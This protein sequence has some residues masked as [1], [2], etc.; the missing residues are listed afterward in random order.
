MLQSTML[1][2]LTFNL[3]RL[4]ASE[5]QALPFFSR[6]AGSPSHLHRCGTRKSMAGTGSWMREWFS[7]HSSDLALKTA[8]LSRAGSSKQLRAHKGTYRNL[9]SWRHLS[10][11]V[12]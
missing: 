3:F 12:D 1:H 6:F 2:V 8:F 4:S 9:A 10:A 11:T 5:A 7:T